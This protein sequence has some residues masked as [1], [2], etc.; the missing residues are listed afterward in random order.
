MT[1]SI[2]PQKEHR[3]RHLRSFAALVVLV[4]AGPALAGSSYTDVGITNGQSYPNRKF[5]RVAE[6]GY[7]YSGT[8]F[9]MVAT[10]TSVL[11][12]KGSAT[13]TVAIKRVCLS[14]A[15]TA[16]GSMP[17]TAVR[18]STAGTLGSA[19]LT[20]VTAGK[21]DTDN[22]TATAVVSTVGTANYTTPGT[23][24]ATLGAGR[25][26]MVALGSAATS[27]AAYPLCWDFSNPLNQGL[28]LKGVLDFLTIDGN[29]AAIPGGGVLDYEIETAEYLP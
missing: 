23:A 9:S 21:L 4:L 28:V 26:S 24:V 20:A 22:A 18:R 7:R 10:P 8:A 3:M 2:T 16:A 1:P 25:L 12:I 6:Q 5:A 15:A 11:V 29:G 13:K 14:G 17:F 27:S 19:V